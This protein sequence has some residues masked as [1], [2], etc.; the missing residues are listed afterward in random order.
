MDCAANSLNSNLGCWKAINYADELK[1]ICT[2]SHDYAIT[3]NNWDTGITLNEE[4][5]KEACHK[6]WEERHAPKL[7]DGPEIPKWTGF[8]EI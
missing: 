7:L 3:K 8:I 6:I 2:S 4:Y 5:I 1:T